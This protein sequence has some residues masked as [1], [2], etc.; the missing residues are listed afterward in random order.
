M[1]SCKYEIYQGKC[2]IVE[3]KRN[4]IVDWFLWHF[5]LSINKAHSPAP[6]PRQLWIVNLSSNNSSWKMPK[7]LVPTGREREGEK[8]MAN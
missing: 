6:A 2:I 3:I 1:L 5:K 7:T 4:Y 8:C